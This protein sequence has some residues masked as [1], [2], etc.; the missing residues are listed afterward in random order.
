E[1]AAVV[2]VAGE[3]WHPGVVGV[4]AGRLRERWRKPVI[5]IGVDPVSGIGKGSGRSQPGV[6][7]G[8]AVQQAYEAGLLLSG[9]GQA[10]AAALAVFLNQALAADQ[11]QAEAEDWVDI[12]ALLDVGA[13]AR[14][15]F[16][17]FDQLAPFGAG[18]P[19]P[20]FAFAG[21]A[22][23]EPVAMNGGHVRL[24]LVGPD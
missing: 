22:A 4:V 12:D 24:R 2:V 1:N 20:L 17:S 3:D 23:R 5:V 11:A 21:V 19:E 10:M 16:E 13:A 6:N 15:L 18:N 9:G 14:D 8:R 7:L